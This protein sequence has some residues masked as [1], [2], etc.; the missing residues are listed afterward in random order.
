MRQQPVEIDLAGARFVAIRNVRDLD[1]ADPGQQAFNG[2]RQVALDD[3][4]VEHVVLQHQVISARGIDDLD[5]FFR[6]VE[7]K[8]GD[9]AR[10]ARLGQQPQPRLLEFGR[11][12]AQVLDQRFPDFLA[13]H[14][15]GRDA[16]Q[17]VQA[18]TTG[19]FRVLD[20]ALDSF[21]EFARALRLAGDASIALRGIAGRQVV[22]HHLDAGGPRPFGNLLRAAEGIGKL[23]FDIT[24]PG[25]CGGREA[26]RKRQLRKQQ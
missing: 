12:K 4:H 17:R 23:V 22:Q 19:G 24:E 5:A 9:G 10:I 20:R 26:L 1:V 3:L 21:A 6:A 16:G 2:L 11:G 13:R 18:R 25:F 7:K 14:A 15:G 8:T